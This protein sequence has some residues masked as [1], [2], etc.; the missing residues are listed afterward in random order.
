MIIIFVNKV[1]LVILQI[2]DIRFGD[3]L[4]KFVMAMLDMMSNQIISSNFTDVK[5]GLI[6]PAKPR[7]E[8]I[9]LRDIQDEKR[10]IIKVKG[11]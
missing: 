8:L 11:T 3:S 4:G 9:F 5:S 1:L 6:N 2:E 7:I 10:I